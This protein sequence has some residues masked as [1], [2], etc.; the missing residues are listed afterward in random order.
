MLHALFLSRCLSRG[1]MMLYST[2]WPQS[3]CAHTRTHTASCAVDTCRLKCCLF[4]EL[5]KGSVS[6][7]ERCL[8]QLIEVS[9]CSMHKTR[10][11]SHHLMC[12]GWKCCMRKCLRFASCYYCRL[13]RPT[14]SS[15]THTYTQTRTHTGAGNPSL[16]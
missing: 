11:S 10:V 14:T 3:L 6:L 1:I 8:V 7:R 5:L 13:R 9:L 12:S 15:F 4:Y 16:L 2:S